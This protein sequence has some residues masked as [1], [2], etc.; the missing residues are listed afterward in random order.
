MFYVEGDLSF[1]IKF[2]LC[3]PF[4]RAYRLLEVFVDL[5]SIP[6]CFFLSIVTMHR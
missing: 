2:F 5:F 6:A 4:F 1:F 3:V